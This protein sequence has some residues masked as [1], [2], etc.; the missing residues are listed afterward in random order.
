MVVNVHAGHAKVGCGAIGA[1]GSYLNESVEDRKVKDKVIELLK[2]NGVEAHDCTEDNGTANQVLKSICS[3]ANAHKAD[4]DISIHFNSSATAS[5]NGTEVLIKKGTTNSKQYAQ[6]ILN[7]ICALGFR[8]RGIK[9]NANLYYLN[10]AKNPALLIECCF[11]GSETDSKLYSADTMAQA[12]VSGIL[13]QTVSTPS[14]TPVETPKVEQPT[15]TQ[16]TTSNAFTGSSSVLQRGSRGEEVKKMQ[17]MLNAV[18]YKCGK[19]DGIFGSGTRSALINFQKANGLTADGVY[20]TK[21]KAKLEE[22]YNCKP[23]TTNVSNGANNNVVEGQK[24]I[25]VTADGIV[26]ANTRKEYAKYCQNMLNADYSSGLT[27][28]G[29]I[30]NS[31][32]RALGNHTVRKGER[33]NLVKVV[34]CGL[35]LLGYSV[36]GIDGIFGS[37]LE[38]A[39]KAFQASKGLATDGIAG[40]N[41]IINIWKAIG[42][43]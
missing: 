3:K 14:N 25:G 42:I 41:T 19:A 15:N 21:S 39:V 29:I 10:H 16:P 43:Y 32:I 20:G 12:I 28:D 18:G 11:V 7:S 13:G 22:V 17:E 38:S 36:N 23:S 8:N 5:A 2:A 40:K 26:G 9:E 6:N 37:G 27:V 34:Q 35:S 30:G 1:V 24:A 31:T 4:L 33:Q